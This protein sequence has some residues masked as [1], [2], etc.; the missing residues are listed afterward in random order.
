MLKVEK[1]N[2]KFDK[3]TVLKDISLGRSI[4]NQKHY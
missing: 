3:K 1:L 2:K 4:D